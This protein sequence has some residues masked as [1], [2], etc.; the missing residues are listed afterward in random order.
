MEPVLVDFTSEFLKLS[1]IWLIDDEISRLT[2]TPSFGVKEQQIWFSKISE[3]SDYLI[4]GI[5]FNSKKIGAC[6]LK[7]ITKNDCEYWGYIGEKA[8]WGR[9]IGTGILRILI[10][11]AKELD[12]DSIWLQVIKTNDRAINLY[13]K[14]N[15]TFEEEKGDIIIMRK[16]I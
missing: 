4:W 14:L 11:K 15:F 8:Y 16:K 7:K 5:E 10:R 13:I 9:G 12:L 1:W 2:N 3:K 6:G